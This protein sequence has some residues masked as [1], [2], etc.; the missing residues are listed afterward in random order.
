MAHAIRSEQVSSNVH[1]FPR[2]QARDSE[3]GLYEA[4]E[5]SALH[6]LSEEQRIAVAELIHAERKH[7]V[8]WWTFLNEMRARRLLPDWIDRQSV[9]NGPDMD[10]YRDGCEA[11]NL[12]LYGTRRVCVA[13]GYC[14]VEFDE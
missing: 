14:S 4:K 11:V 7:A 10:R 13:G 6:G 1:P 8:Q 5:G 12:A 9:G 3:P 2:P